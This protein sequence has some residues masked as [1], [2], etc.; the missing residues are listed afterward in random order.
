MTSASESSPCHCRYTSPEGHSCTNP[1]H[2]NDSQLCFWHDPEADKSGDD[3]CDRLEA[4]AVTGQPMDGFVLR[5]ANL[6]QLNLNRLQGH[7]RYRMRYVDLY[8]AKLARAHLY[9]IDLTGSNLMKSD[10]SWANLNSA[11]L[12]GCNLL[13]VNLK[14]ARLEDVNWGRKVLQAAE[15]DRAS[16]AGDDA[17]AKSMYL[18]AESV[19]RNIRRVAEQQGLVDTAGHFFQ[20]EMKNRRNQFP[21]D[22]WQRASSWLVDFVSGYGERPLRVITFSVMMIM[23]FAV[24]YF[25]TGV[26]YNGVDLFFDPHASWLK[27]LQT[28]GYC[29]YFSVVTFTTLGYGDIVPVSSARALAALEAFGGSFM[30]A[31]FVVVFVKKMTR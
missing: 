18:E 6:E 23:V 19:C 8:R 16:K 9:D 7:D 28:F 10:F 14:N 12:D 21:L 30:I 5:H 31:L 13:G 25:F 29:A 4:Y 24:A 17:L 15:A 27:N 2:N 26:N 3:L 1:L 11:Q 22:S 20:Q